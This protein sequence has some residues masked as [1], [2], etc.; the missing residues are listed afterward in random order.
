MKT[1]QIAATFFEPS[2]TP[3]NAYERGYKYIDDVIYDQ[4]NPSDAMR[5]ILEFVQAEHCKLGVPGKPHL[6]RSVLWI[7]CTA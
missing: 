3:H 1:K 4:N 7:V 6:S 5:E 2:L